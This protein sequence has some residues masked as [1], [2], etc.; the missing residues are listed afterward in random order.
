MKARQ[1]GAFLVPCALAVIATAGQPTI[2]PAKVKPTTV[3]LQAAGSIFA[4]DPLTCLTSNAAALKSALDAW[5]A[6]PG[7]TFSKATG[8]GTIGW[9]YY[10]DHTCVNACKSDKAAIDAILAK[11]K[12][13]SCAQLTVSCMEIPG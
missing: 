10:N 9:C 13:T 3:S 2:A 1:I 8:G 6:I 12:F 5:K 4:V 7:L 11:C